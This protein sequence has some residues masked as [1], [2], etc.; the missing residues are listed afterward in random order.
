MFFHQNELPGQRQP[1]AEEQELNSLAVA[2]DR[3]YQGEGYQGVGNQEQHWVCMEEV[4]LS[5]LAVAEEGLKPQVVK[6]KGWELT[7][8]GREN[9]E[10]VGIVGDCMKVV[11]DMLKH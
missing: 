6:D 7:V 5:C 9:C 8:G 4:G 3:G 2:E 10:Q 1:R 11:E